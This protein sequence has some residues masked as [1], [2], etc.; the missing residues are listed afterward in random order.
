ML[1]IRMLA[2]TDIEVADQIMRAAYRTTS[3]RMQVL[4]QNLLI[5]PDGWFLAELEQQPVGLVGATNYGPFAYAGSM[6]VLPS[7]Q[8]RG[9][10]AA[11]LEHLLRWLELEQHC[12]TILLDATKEGASLYQRFAFQDEDTVG[13]WV[14]P[15]SAF[16]THLGHH[17]D[18]IQPLQRETLPALTAF[19]APYFGAARAIIFSLLTLNYPDQQ[20]FVSYD[21]EGDISGYLFV[22]GRTLGPWVARRNEDAE[23]LLRHVLVLSSAKPLT[24]LAPALNTHAAALLEQ[25]GFHPQRI[26]RHMRRGEPVG[27]RERTKIYGQAS[28]SLG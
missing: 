8:R 4:R 21:E 15:A 12:S 16:A 7:M 5:Q 18:H 1:S 25:Y 23:A 14:R 6:S 17:D 26:L 28:F 3:S 10:G 11:L 13:H 22:N 24:V 2:D 9:I 27:L 20:S 19:D